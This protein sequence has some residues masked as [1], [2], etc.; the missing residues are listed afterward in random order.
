MPVVSP[1]RRLPRPVVVMG[2]AVVSRVAVEACTRRTRQRLGRR[3]SNT[4]G[5][6]CARSTRM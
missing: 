1:M 5:R 6:N 4:N 3:T 2:V